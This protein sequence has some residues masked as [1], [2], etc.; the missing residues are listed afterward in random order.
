MLW[1]A[2]QVGFKDSHAWSWP[3]ESGLRT[4]MFHYGPLSWEWG[5]PLYSVAP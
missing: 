5:L 4:A 1:H 2:S 3:L